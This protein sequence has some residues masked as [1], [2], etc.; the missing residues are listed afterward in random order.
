MRATGSD[1]EPRHEHAPLECLEGGTARE[2]GAPTGLGV[3]IGVIGRQ[4]NGGRRGLHHHERII[5]ILSARRSMIENPREQ[6]YYG[7]LV[8]ICERGDRQARPD[9]EHAREYMGAS[10]SSQLRP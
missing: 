3:P 1:C 7:Q 2:E 4:S 6:S 8:K 10:R 9:L 5:S